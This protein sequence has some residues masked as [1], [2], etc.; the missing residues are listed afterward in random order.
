MKLMYG[1]GDKGIDLREHHQCINSKAINIEMMAKKYGDWQKIFFYV[2]FSNLHLIQSLRTR[3]PRRRGC[4]GREEAKGGSATA[5]IK[6][7]D[8]PATCD[9]SGNPSSIASNAAGMTPK[10]RGSDPAPRTCPKAFST[11]IECRFRFQPSI[12]QNIAYVITS[13]KVEVSLP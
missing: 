3:R 7:K 11:L 10:D 5:A 13:P 9:G 1:T 12:N 6:E 8:Y 2:F 4:G